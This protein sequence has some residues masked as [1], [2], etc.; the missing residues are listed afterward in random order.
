M[1]LEFYGPW[2][3]A[4]IPVDMRDCVLLQAGPESGTPQWVGIKW[5]GAKMNSELADAIHEALLELAA[6]E[7]D[8]E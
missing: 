7:K 2:A 1:K 5:T 8:R 3:D 6:K 4:I